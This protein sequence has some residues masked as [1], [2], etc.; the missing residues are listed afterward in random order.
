MQTILYKGEMDILE[1]LYHMV[2]LQNNITYPIFYI[3][4]KDINII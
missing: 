2:L 1:E 4:G 3:N